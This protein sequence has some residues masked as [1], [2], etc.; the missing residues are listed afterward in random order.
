MQ[1]KLIFTRNFVYLASFWKWRFLELRS[2]LLVRYKPV[3][4]GWW[5]YEYMKII[6]V[7][8]GV[9][10]YM[11]E[12][13]RR[14][15]RNFCSCKTKPE[16]NSGLYGIRTVDLSDHIIVYPAVHI[17]DFHMPC[18][19]FWSFMFPKHV[20]F[21]SFTIKPDW[22]VHF[23]KGYSSSLGESGCSTCG[24]ILIA[25]RLQNCFNKYWS[26]LHHYT[27]TAVCD[28]CSGNQCY[29]FHVSQT[30]QGYQLLSTSIDTVWH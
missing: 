18:H 26:D 13:H 7:N 27:L 4:G 1:I 30:Y 20:N 8:C 5:S 24:V 17:Y 12:D 28:R 19:K 22:L 9:K 15:V 6:Y 29:F 14:Y 11:K 21:I 25:S 2:G 10:N 3:K 23:I 16:K